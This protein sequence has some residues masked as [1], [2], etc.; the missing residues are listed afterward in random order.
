[1]ERVLLNVGCGAT[2]PLG[3]VNVDCSLNAWIQRT[4]LGRALAR[5]FIRSTTYTSTNVRYINLNR[6]WPWP[7]QSVDVVYGSHVFEHLRLRS[8]ALFLS[9]A[10]RVLKPGGVIRLVVPD[11]YKLAKRY[12]TDF[13]NG[14][15]SASEPFLYALNLHLENSTPGSKNVFFRLI[16]FLQGHPHQH[17]YMYDIASMRLRLERAGF[18]ELRESV[19]GMSDLIPEIRDVEQTGEGI[20]ALYIEA[21]RP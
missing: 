5:R 17:K 21:L 9:E 19:Y 8:A 13:E 4:G 18:S 14:Q 7:D 16:H 20:P 6:R 3:W 11:L 1:M 2:R 10:G 12:V 15:V